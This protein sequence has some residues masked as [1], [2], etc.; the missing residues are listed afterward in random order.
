VPSD[1]SLLAVFAAVK[2]KAMG[3]YTEAATNA[4]LV[5]RPP[6]PARIVSERRIPEIGV[7]DWRLANGVRV[8]FKATDFKDDE[9]LFGATGP[10]GTSLAADSLFVPATFAADLVG[11]SGVG[12]Y[13]SIDLQK[14]LAG[15][16][17]FVQPTLGPLSGGLTGRASPKDVETL[18]Q[19]IYLYFTAPRLD[20]ASY[21][22]FKSNLEAFL[23]NRSAD[24]G[25][26]FDDTLEVTLAQHHFRARPLTSGTLDAMNL[27]RSLGF[28]RDRF[29]HAGDFTFVFVGSFQ[30]DSLRPLVQSYLGGLPSGGGGETWRDVGIRPPAGVIRRT[31]RKGVEPKS[32][33]QIA[34]TGT[35]HD[36]QEDRLALRSL[37]EVLQ[38]ML[39]D[40]L[41]EEMGATYGVAVDWSTS[42]Y[43]RQEYSLTVSFGAAPE[44]LD[45]LVRVVFHQIDSLKQAGPSAS[46]VQKVTEAQHR[47]LETWRTQNDYWFEQLIL[48]V[49]DNDDP[50]LLARYGEVIDRLNAAVIRDA[51]RRYLRADNY[52]QVSL[53]PET[54]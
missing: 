6:A 10:G 49:E 12:S 32:R 38:L 4:E 37:A 27:Q 14:R 40:R 7:R 45:S 25:A 34:F 19:L 53:Y 24:P 8:L 51:A 50:R 48:Y 23:Q 16:A 31:V 33:T 9:I 30:P 52:V 13:N 5:A 26:A 54:R 28:Y 46:D 20:S 1:A 29:A 11:S 3:P 17:V 42:R 35:F 44:R 15:K 18:F 22:A 43:P 36:T 2:E 41:R 21:L 47:A 39:R